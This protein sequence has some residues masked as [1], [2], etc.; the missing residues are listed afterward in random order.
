MIP[1][2]PRLAVSLSVA[3][4]WLGGCSP[5]EKPSAQ[6]P[7]SAPPPAAAGVRTVSITGDDT[8]K[9]NVT[10]VAAAPGEPLRVVFTNVGK[11]PKQAMAHNWVLLQPCSEAELNAFGTA[12][13]LAAPTHIPAAKQAQVIAHTKLLGPGESDTIDFKAPSQPGEYPFIC[14]FPGHFAMMRGKLVVK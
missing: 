5:A 4:L 12:A 6:T 10:E 9:F 2:L 14:T 7:P 8:M 1:S 3:A 13:V 11:L